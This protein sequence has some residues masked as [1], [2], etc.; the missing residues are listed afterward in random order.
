MLAH[1]INL[2]DVDR[3]YI[4]AVFAI[5]SLVAGSERKEAADVLWTKLLSAHVK[6]CISPLLL[7]EVWHKTLTLTFKRDFPGEMFPK[8]EPSIVQRYYPEI[9]R[10]TDR[11]L[12][13][14]NVEL[15]GMP[16]QVKPLVE[17]ALHLV[18]C[19]NLYPRDAFHLALARSYGI[20]YAISNDEQWQHSSIETPIVLQF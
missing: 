18:Q 16:T 9:R 19:A 12:N 3:V 14:P 7:D 2:S 13:L 20:R 15:L 17:D 1:R 4:D 5:A 10:I 6:V 8:S 11:L